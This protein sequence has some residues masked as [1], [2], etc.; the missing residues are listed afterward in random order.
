MQKSWFVGIGIAAVASIGSAK[1]QDTYEGD[2]YDW[3]GAYIGLHAGG[4]W[5]EATDNLVETIVGN[6]GGGP[7][8]GRFDVD[9]A[10]GGFHAGYN[11]QSGGFV[12]GLEADVQGSGVDG[13]AGHWGSSIP[14]SLIYEG[15]LSL[16]PE[17]IASL[18]G[19]VGY[20]FNGVLVYATAGIAASDAELSYAGIRHNGATEGEPFAY[21][22]SQTHLGFTVGAGVEVAFGENWSGRVE[23]RYFDFGE[24]TY[25]FPTGAVDADFDLISISTGLSYRF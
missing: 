4:G 21:S 19:R 1:A 3:W 8:S 14:F 13:G 18:R 5:G 6:A 25:D 16:D 11:I 22:E 7:N 10:L 24:E 12:A 2:A 9:G 23:A 20:A 17:W 15:F